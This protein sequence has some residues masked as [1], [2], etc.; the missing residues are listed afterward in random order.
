MSTVWDNARVGVTAASG[1]QSDVDV[2][3][4]TLRSDET[5]SASI[6][7]PSITVVGVA[8]WRSGSPLTEFLSDSTVT[9]K[10]S[11]MYLPL[12]SQQGY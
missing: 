12:C 3:A 4:L 8:S 6:W 10:T 5:A 11:D 9:T 7:G 1:R 2:R